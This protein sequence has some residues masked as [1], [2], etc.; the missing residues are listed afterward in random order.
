MKSTSKTAAFK[1]TI[2]GVFVV[3]ATL[4]SSA[5]SQTLLDVNFDD[6][7]SGIYSESDVGDDF[8]ELDFTNGVTE[9]RAE[10]V[11]GQAAFGGSGASLMVSYPAGSTG[12]REGGAQWLVELDT[13][14]EEAYLTYRVKF[15][16]GF[17]FVRGG[18]LPGLAG[19]SAPSG[20]APADGIRGW[21]GRM[22]WRNNFTGVS[23]QPQQTV[24]R[25][26]SYAKH[27]FSG[28][29]RDGRQEDR[30]FWVEDDGS[31]TTMVAGVWYTC[32]LYTSDAADE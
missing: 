25:G 30:V 21:T 27:V 28:F 4:S 10:L 5:H 18:K 19:G 3:F 1:I 15:R 6:C 2:I 26:I 7:V 13:E 24:T 29:D 14:T 31:D 12:P 8:G 32:L 9:G 16:D 22:M 23:G 17:D 11:G 20:N